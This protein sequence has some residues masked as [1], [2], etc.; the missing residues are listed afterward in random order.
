MDLSNPTVRSQAV[1]EVAQIFNRIKWLIVCSPL[2]YCLQ[3]TGYQQ[4]KHFAVPFICP[5]IWIDQFFPLLISFCFP[6]FPF[7]Q[8]SQW[9]S[10]S[11]QQCTDS[12]EGGRGGGGG[13]SIYFLYRDVPTVRVSFSG[14]SVLNR[15]HNFTFSCLKQGHSASFGNLLLYF[16]FDHMIFADFMRLCWN[17]WRRKL[18]CTVLSVLNTA[19]LIQ[20]WTGKKLQPFLLDRVAK[21]ASLCLEQGQGFVELAERPYPNSRWVHPPG[22]YSNAHGAVYSIHTI[23]R[24][25]GNAE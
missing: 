15:V 3:S 18:I 5:F 24:K 17:V 8:A 4:R 22:L 11:S 12:C 9:V 7:H 25:Y 19:C 21:F 14:S 2:L 6:F 13:T 10:Q 23:D 20:S 1:K 16:P